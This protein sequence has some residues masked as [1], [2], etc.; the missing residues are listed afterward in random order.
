V[1]LPSEADPTPACSF[2]FS[3]HLAEGSSLSDLGFQAPICKGSFLFNT[4]VPSR[5][6]LGAGKIVQV[7]KPLASRPDNPGPTQWKER[8]NSQN[9][10]SPSQQHHHSQSY[11]HIDRYTDTH[12]EKHTQRHTHTTQMHS[13]HTNI[14]ISAM[15]GGGE[16][17][18]LTSLFI[19]P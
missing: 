11:T 9:V 7:M 8:T 16:K 19:P 14:P 17:H 4:V 1:S 10:S 6:S 2:H 15:G 12:T 3:C 5:L 13:I 18:I